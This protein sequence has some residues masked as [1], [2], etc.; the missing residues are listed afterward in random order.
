VPHFSYVGDSVLGHRAHLGAG[1]KISN[2]KLGGGAVRVEVN[3]RVI[4]TGLRK[5]GALIG[6]HVDVGCN[7]VLNPGSIIGRNSIVYPAVNW[8]GYLAPGQIAKNRAAIEITP[9]RVRGE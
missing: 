7:A 9:R 4:D 5:F 1:V 3:G 8:R 6:D 2:L